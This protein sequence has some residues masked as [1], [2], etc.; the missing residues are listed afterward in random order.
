M[1]VLYLCMLSASVLKDQDG[2][3][4]IVVH[5]LHGFI[6]HVVHR[7]CGI[8][9][10]QTARHGFLIVVICEVRVQLLV[11]RVLAEEPAEKGFL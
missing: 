10:S 1:E 2:D 7:H 3:V 6:K 5:F 9:E 8:V 4:D 11:F